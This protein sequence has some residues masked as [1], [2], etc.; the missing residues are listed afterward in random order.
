MLTARVNIL[1]CL[2]VRSITFDL[3]ITFLLIYLP[4]SNGWL[5]ESTILPKKQVPIKIDEASM[6]D[7]KAVLIKEKPKLSN[8]A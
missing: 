3:I 2:S 1:F 5:T 8:I 4:M 7:F 6:A